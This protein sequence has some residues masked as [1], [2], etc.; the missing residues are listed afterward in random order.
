MTPLMNTK[1][2]IVCVLKTGGSIG[3]DSEW[4]Y[5]LKRGLDRNITIPFNFY[6]LS[7]IEISDIDVINLEIYRPEPA[8][9]FWYK[10]QLFKHE[11]FVNNPTLY[12]DLDIVLCQNIDA[13]I[14][15]L[16]NQTNFVMLWEDNTHRV[17]VPST[18]NSSI[19]YW[20]ND[21]R[22]LWETFIKNPTF[23]FE[24]HSIKESFGDQGFIKDNVDHIL[25]QDLLG[26]EK[27]TWANRKEGEPDTTKF[28]IFT[29]PSKKPH[30]FQR[31]SLVKKNWI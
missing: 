30:K 26:Y 5:K 14:E 4:V 8:H 28:L 20:N 21:Y 10:M 11:V 9:L 1:I 12:I 19:M 18:S 17:N 22:F 15:K 24:K 25:M 29:K 3:Y 16:I 27:F 7:D 2:N 6:C 13:E 23:F 31:H